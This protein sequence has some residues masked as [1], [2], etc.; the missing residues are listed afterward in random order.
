MKQLAFF[1]ISSIP[2][3]K[4]IAQ[5]SNHSFEPNQLIF[6]RLYFYLK[7]RVPHHDKSE[8]FGSIMQHPYLHFILMALSLYENH[9]FTLFLLDCTAHQKRSKLQH[10][11]LVTLLP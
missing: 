8:A 6:Y 7:T 10:T 11:T 3:L 1:I 9:K 2:S 5:I 4:T